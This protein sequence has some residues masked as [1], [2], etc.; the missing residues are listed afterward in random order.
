MV[1]A[2]E[3]RFDYWSSRN[4]EVRTS[5]GKSLLRSLSHLY[6]LEFHAPPHL[7]QQRTQRNPHYQPAYYINEVP[8]SV[9]PSSMLPRYSQNSAVSCSISPIPFKNQIS[10]VLLCSDSPTRC[11]SLRSFV[12]SLVSRSLAQLIANE[13]LYD[14]TYRASTTT[15]YRVSTAKNIPDQTTAR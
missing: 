14:Q 5:S 15:S 2:V 3:I 12:R 8:S 11:I 13:P 6:I 1:R 4:A 9:T 7:D 10:F